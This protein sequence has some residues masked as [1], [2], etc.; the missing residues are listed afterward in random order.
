M[1]SFRLR[2]FFSAVRRFSLRLRSLLYAAEVALKLQALTTSAGRFFQVRF[3]KAESVSVW[4]SSLLGEIS[5]RTIA[6]T[7]GR[8]TTCVLTT[9]IGDPFRR[10]VVHVGDP[11]RRRM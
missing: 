3:G 5:T 11:F 2:P 9:C 4:K 1:A 8:F 6:S 7:T 10:R